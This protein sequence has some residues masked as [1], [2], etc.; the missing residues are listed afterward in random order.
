CARRGE[1]G[2]YDGYWFAYW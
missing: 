2:T 1:I